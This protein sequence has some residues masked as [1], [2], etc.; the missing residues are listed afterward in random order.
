MAGC[1]CARCKRWPKPDVGNQVRAAWR[2]GT[3]V[4]YEFMIGGGRLAPA[5]MFFDISVRSRLGECRAAG[6]V[7][8]KIVLTSE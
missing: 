6:T 5:R 1:T 4:G 8:G 3:V 2:G 7:E